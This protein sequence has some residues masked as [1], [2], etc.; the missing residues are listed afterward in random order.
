MVGK[1]SASGSSVW[2]GYGFTVVAKSAELKID[3]IL[4]HVFWK[5]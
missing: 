2:Q 1:K 4:L 5:H 3:Q